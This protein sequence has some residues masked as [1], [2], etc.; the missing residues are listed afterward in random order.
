MRLKDAIKRRWGT[1]TDKDLDM[2]EVKLDQLPG[3]LQVTYDSASEEA[4]K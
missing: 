1:V 4:E 3:K 2:V